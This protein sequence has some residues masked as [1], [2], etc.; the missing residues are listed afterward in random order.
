MKLATGVEANLFSVSL[1]AL[2]FDGTTQLKT[3]GYHIK[4]V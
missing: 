3:Y 1:L 4:S 2:D